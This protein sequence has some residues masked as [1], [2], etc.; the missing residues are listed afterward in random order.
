MVSGNT[1]ALR[2]TLDNYDAVKEFFKLENEAMIVAATM[3][4]FSMDTIIEQ[5]VGD[6]VNAITVPLLSQVLDLLNLL[7]S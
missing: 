2:D 3:R 7:L 5:A 1:N 6:D 4:Y